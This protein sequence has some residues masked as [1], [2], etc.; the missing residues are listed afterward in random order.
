M[1]GSTK[2]VTDGWLRPHFG[3]DLYDL[4]HRYRVAAERKEG[5]IISR[6]LWT[7]AYSNW[8]NP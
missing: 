5:R 3:V 7:T 4:S 6:V 2:V 8:G 1:N